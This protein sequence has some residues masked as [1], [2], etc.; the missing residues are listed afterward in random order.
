MAIPSPALGPAIGGV[1]DR[2]QSIRGGEVGLTGLDALRRARFDVRMG[3]GR[4]PVLYRVVSAWSSLRS[5]DTRPLVTART[6]LVIDGFPRSGNGFSNFALR[7]AAKQH[8]TH[9]PVIAHHLHNPGQVV[10]AAR[11]GIPVLLL[12][13]PPRATVLSVV[14]R[15]PHLRIRQVLRAYVGYYERVRSVASQ[16]VVGTFD[17]VTTDFGAVTTAV[18][19]R[20]GISLPVFDHS[21]DNVRAVYNPDHAGRVARRREETERMAELDDP[22]IAG[23]LNRAEEL[24][25][26]F[27]KAQSLSGS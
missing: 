5:R 24:Y 23:L 18:N 19:E 26:W 9:L 7:H 21:P 25:D 1:A 10:A 3:L 14:S 2:L 15:W 12:V 13:R 20:F 17:A 8:G 4:L 11:L 16:A 6:V 22:G 27:V